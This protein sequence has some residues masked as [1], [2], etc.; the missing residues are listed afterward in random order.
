MAQPQD[1]TLSAAS[2][3]L[4]WDLAGLH[5]LHLAFPEL[6]S[7]SSCNP[8]SRTLLKGKKPHQD[9]SHYPQ[10]Y[11]VLFLVDV[12]SLALIPTLQS[13]LGTEHP[14]CAIHPGN[15]VPVREEQPLEG[16]QGP[17]Y[18]GLGFIP[19]VR[20]GLLL[21]SI[22]CLLSSG[23]I[24]PLLSLKLHLLFSTSQSTWRTIAFS[25]RSLFLSS[26]CMFRSL[27]LCKSSLVTLSSLLDCGLPELHVF[28]YCLVLAKQSLLVG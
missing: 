3:A 7:F 1:I 16:Q 22:Y 5:C 11:W 24:C 10:E 6:P 8:S 2:P 17:A 4:K 21:L 9:Y 12:R 15:L 28:S 23:H 20:E 18:V 13:S 25:N 27:C 26:L 14:L 19:S